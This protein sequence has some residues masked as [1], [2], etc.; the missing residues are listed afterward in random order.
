MGSKPT[1]DGV[2][3]MV[4]FLA[5]RASPKLKHA[6]GRSSRGGEAARV[7]EISFPM[8]L[9]LLYIGKGQGV[10]VKTHLG[11][12]SNVTWSPSPPLP[13]SETD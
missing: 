5:D 3:A 12:A 10:G 9:P 8:S 2:E 7:L 11:P 13:F 6:R 1:T 4:R